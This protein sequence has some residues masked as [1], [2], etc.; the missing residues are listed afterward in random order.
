MANDTIDISNQEDIQ[1]FKNLYNKAKSAGTNSFIFR[2]QPILVS[3]AKYL[4][5]Y[6]EILAKKGMIPKRRK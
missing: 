3:Y 5:E 1:S 2:G 6:V 4:L